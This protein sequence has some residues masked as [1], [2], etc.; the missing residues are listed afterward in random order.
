MLAKQA[1]AALRAGDGV[2]RMTLARFFA[3]N[4]S[5]QAGAFERIVTEGAGSIV[6]TG[7]NL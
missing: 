5:V 4:I 7:G 1:L 2:G 3:E 6:S